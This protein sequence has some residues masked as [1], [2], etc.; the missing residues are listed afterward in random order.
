MCDS[1]SKTTINLDKALFGVRGDLTPILKDSANPFF[2][3]SYAGLGTTI[4]TLDPVFRDHGILVLQ[5]AT[6]SSVYEGVVVLNIT[7]ELIHVES[8]EF[9]INTLTLPLKSQDP[10][11]LGSA[12]TYGRRYLW[13]LVAGA[14]VED[15]D[16]NGATFGNQAPPAAKKSVPAGK[17]KGASANGS[18]TNSASSET[19]SKPAVSPKTTSKTP[20][21]GKK[22]EAASSLPTKTAAPTSAFSYK[23]KD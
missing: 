4:Q 10:Q 12:V 22:K 17:Y 19:T 6:Q 21:F 8:G 16:G 2:K 18:S 3:S 23:P 1:R 13:Q 9:R 20:T 11:Q 14:E 15:D 7:T 5:G